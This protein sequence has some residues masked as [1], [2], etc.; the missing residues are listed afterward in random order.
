MNTN[1]SCGKLKC[2]KVEL[3]LIRISHK[4]EIRVVDPIETYLTKLSNQISKK[5]FYILSVEIILL[6]TTRSSW[7]LFDCDCVRHVDKE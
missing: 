3:C 2:Q 1:D 7:T 4:G 5:N 6:W